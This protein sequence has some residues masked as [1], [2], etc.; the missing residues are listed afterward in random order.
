[1]FAGWHW[2]PCG[3][4]APKDNTIYHSSCWWAQSCLMACKCLRFF[5]VLAP[6]SHCGN[7][8]LSWAKTVQSLI[9][10]HNLSW[11][12]Q[13]SWAIPTISCADRFWGD[14]LWYIPV[15]FTSFLVMFWTLIDSSRLWAAWHL[16]YV[17]PCLDEVIPMFLLTDWWLILIYADWWCTL[18]THLL[19]HTALTQSDVMMTSQLYYY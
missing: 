10:N 11:D 1:M 4:V 8:F 5:F 13:K 6:I 15:S 7:K 9:Y 16:H 12:G 18:M 17:I 3:H 19:T 14:T 2:W